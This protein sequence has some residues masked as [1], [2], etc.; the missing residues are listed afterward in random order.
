MADARI[1]AEIA[2][3]PLSPLQS[4]F[5]FME[6]LYPGA[7][8]H[9]LSMVLAWRGAVET[10]LLIEA[11]RRVADRHPSLRS[12]FVG[13]G[14]SVLQR[15]AASAAADLVLEEGE[16]VGFTRLALELPPLVRDAAAA[17][18]DL[19][20]GPVFRARIYRLNA[21]THAILLSMHHIVADGW[22]VGIIARDIA[23]TYQSLRGAAPAMADSAAAYA[24][25]PPVSGSAP[26]FK[27]EYWLKLL[28]GAP[29]ALELPGTSH[30]PQ[31]HRGIGSTRSAE[32][33]PE[34]TAKVRALCEAT[35]ASV[36]AVCASTAFIL[37][38]R[39]TGQHDI[40]VG[41]P[42]ANRASRAVAEVVGLFV[43]ALPMRLTIEGSWR[44]ADVLERIRVALFRALMHQDVPFE[45]LVRELNPPRRPGMHPIFQVTLN[46]ADFREPVHV[47]EDFTL[48]MWP[49]LNG[50][51]TFDL[52][53]HFIENS[54]GLS[55]LVNYNSDLF[56]AALIER[57]IR[58]F[59]VLLEEGV[60]SPDIPLVRLSVFTARELTDLVTGPYESRADAQ[61]VCL[62]QLFERQA[63]RTP[64]QPA[65]ITLDESLSYR[66]LDAR[67]RQVA[68][69]L[70]ALG[71]GPESLVGLCASRNANCLA[72]L[73]GILKSNA[74]YVPLD[75][76]YPE[77]RLALI[78]TSCRPLAVVADSRNGPA[79]E[80]IRA[81]GWQGP[82]IFVDEAAAAEQSAAEAPRR[83]VPQNLAYCFYTSGSTGVPK[84]VMVEH[85]SAASFVRWMLSTF[86]AADL[87][88]V[89]FSTSINFDISILEIFSP[90]ASGGAVV[91]AENIVEFV[92]RVRSFPA[93]SLI[94]TV[95]SALPVLLDSGAIAGYPGV[96]N[97]GGEALA[98]PLATRVHR[99]VPGIRL[100]NLYGPTEATVYASFGAVSDAPSAPVTLGRPV[101][102][103][104]LYVLDEH[105]RPVPF[106]GQGEI[107]IGGPQ[108]AR[109]YFNRPGLTAERFIPSPFEAGEGQRLYRTGD[110]ARLLSSGEIEY[111][112]RRDFQI[113]L[114]GHRIELGDIEAAL[115]SHPG[116]DEAVVV[117]RED[118]RG[119]QRLI[120][121]VAPRNDVPLLVESSL[122]DHV[123][124]RVPAIMI[125]AEIVLLARLPRAPNGKLDRQSLPTADLHP[126]TTPGARSS[127]E[128]SET[129]RALAEI[130]SEELRRPD[131]GDRDDFF[132]RGGHSLLATQVAVR[133]R[134]RFEV[135]FT[136]RDLFEAPILELCARRI[137]RLQLEPRADAAVI[138]RARRVRTR[139]AR[140]RDDDRAKDAT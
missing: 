47:A 15:V 54:R 25:P 90:L 49:A 62:H 129:E 137:E 92:E 82:M 23:R 14:R 20:N 11:I 126:N 122:K 53:L 18:F 80:A 7:R 130:W 115:L 24:L 118:A 38:A 1:C 4:Q 16:P 104:T 108:V 94:N 88:A 2:A 48:E 8:D 120:A 74:A 127:R 107:Y 75:P 35:G 32:F 19:E 112:G 128:L 66:E 83:A 89:L 96:L 109:G 27:T 78:L 6:S 124:A 93:V 21:G 58:H 136:V 76:A 22:S 13:S 63:A 103:T 106:G 86:D 135:D 57:W 117:A 45:Q 12:R 131:V 33:S 17:A 101:T 91:I 44:F 85:A 69:R 26:R 116:V 139:I 50:G 29:A 40:V 98:R 111:V 36:F 73:L 67:A 9:I 119:D 102:S 37:L 125:P 121:F 59:E 43:N 123:A 79:A 5:W 87:R 132:A 46:H 65:V 55:L 60:S 81:A 95:P 41:V 97:V 140:V 68:Q 113:K 133:V 52:D 34:L 71:A 31:V 110:I 64:L 70:T 10:P 134:Q 72:A 56:D 114:R 61:A 51:A 77:S 42:L 3:A 138:P 100:N 84:G 105:L 39:L 30:R 99:A 28:A